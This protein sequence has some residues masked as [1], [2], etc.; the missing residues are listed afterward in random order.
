M[1]DDGLSL[2]LA[3]VAGRLIR[4]H[5]ALGGDVQRSVTIPGKR[6]QGG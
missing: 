2:Y 3:S 1:D 5:R 4:G 6:N